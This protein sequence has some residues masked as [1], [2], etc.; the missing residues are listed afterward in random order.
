MA[1]CPLCHSSEDVGWSTYFQAFK[2]TE[3]KIYF[4]EDDTVRNLQKRIAELEK[5]ADWLAEKM[6]EICNNVPEC[7]NCPFY[8]DYGDN[9]CKAGFRTLAKRAVAGE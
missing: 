1:V 5:E 3:C 7:L 9:L 2:C 6:K 8:R 4:E